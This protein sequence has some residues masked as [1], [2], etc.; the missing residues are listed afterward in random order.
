MTIKTTS[1]SAAA[2][3]AV[4]AALAFD[5]TPPGTRQPDASGSQA[6]PAAQRPAPCRSGS[7]RRPAR[8]RTR[9][10]RRASRGPQPKG[11]TNV[12]NS[13]GPA[14]GGSGACSAH[15]R[16]TVQNT[17]SGVSSS[18]SSSLIS[19][20]GSSCS[21]SAQTTGS[22]GAGTSECAAKVV[23]DGNVVVDEH[24]TGRPGCSVHGTWP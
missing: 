5:V 21:V 10:H 3:L 14:A 6:T 18:S 9:K 19:S 24:Q 15:V 20:G 4:V 8:C 13:N 11:G 2:V 22:G 17:G 7:Q 23:V 1:A 12:T 16:T